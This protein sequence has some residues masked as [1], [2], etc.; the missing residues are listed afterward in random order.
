[1]SKPKMTLEKVCIDKSDVFVYALTL[2]KTLMVVTFATLFK[3]I[4]C[5]NVRVKR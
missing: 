3:K 4:L 5:L 1:M 2:F